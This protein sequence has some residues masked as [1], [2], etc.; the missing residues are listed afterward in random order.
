MFA[1]SMKAVRVGSTSWAE[2]MKIFEVVM[3]SNHF[4]IQP[5][6]VGKNAGAPIIWRESQSSEH[7]VMKREAVLYLQISDQASRDS[8]Q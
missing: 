3:G 2:R 5:Q 4:L 6:T 7:V 8:V 1:M